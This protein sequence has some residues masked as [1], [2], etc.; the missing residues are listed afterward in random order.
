MCNMLW[1]EKW[2]RR[3]KA[4][5]G[6]E[7]FDETLVKEKLVW[8]VSICVMQT[9]C[10]LYDELEVSRDRYEYVGWEPEMTMHLVDT[11]FI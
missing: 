8:N 11:T 2:P 7:D 4:T 5:I 3:T 10:N 6:L 9:K 1:M